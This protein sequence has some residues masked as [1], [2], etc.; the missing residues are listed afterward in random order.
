MNNHSTAPRRRGR[1]GRAAT[2][3]L[4]ATTAVMLAAASANALP[5]PGDGD[6]EPPP[7]GTLTISGRVSLS[8]CP[9]VSP[10]R[11]TVTAVGT[12]PFTGGVGSDR[13]SSTGAYTITDLPPG[14]YN[15]VAKLDAGVCPYGAWTPTSQQVF[16]PRTGVNFAYRGPSKVLRLSAPL[17]AGVLNSTVQGTQLHLDNYGPLHGQSH[18]QDNAS[19]L[20]WGGVTYPFTLP[21]IQYDLDCGTFCPDIGQARFYVDDMNMTSIAVGWLRPSFRGTLAFESNGPEVKGWFTDATTGI[22]SDS[23]MPD[24]N[25]DN[26]RLAVALT[27]IAEG[28]RLSY[29]VASV[30]LSANIQATGPCGFIW[31]VCNFFTSYKAKIKSE[32]ENGV[33]TKLSDPSVRAFAAAALDTFLTARG[34]PTV[35]RVFIEGD[36]LVLVA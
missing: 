20:R 1:W 12:N 24:V 36:T 35:N 28:G 14:R 21:E 2:L 34:M 16:A 33:R 26:A 13:P 32:I 17:V 8:S 19:F 18:Q 25:I 11:V 10:D 4:I 15:V 5:P 31:D 22:E 7:E 29:R 23:L 6:P 27:P 3:G 9:G 30:S